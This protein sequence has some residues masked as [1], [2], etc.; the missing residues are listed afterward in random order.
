MSSP[1]YLA[2]GLSLAWPTAPL[3][4]S[5]LLMRR[6]MRAKKTQA[7][8]M[9]AAGMT[10]LFG[11]MWLLNALVRLPSFFEPASPAQ[12]TWIAV[13]YDAA[14]YLSMSFTL[15]AGVF[16]LVLRRAQRRQP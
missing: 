4:M 12:A 9:V 1:D 6:V 14:P 13:N 5:F 2:L 3:V 10:Q 7:V 8:A 16:W 11:L 15:L